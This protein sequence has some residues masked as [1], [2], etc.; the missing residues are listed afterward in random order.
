[1]K[2]IRMFAAS[3]LCMASLLSGCATFDAIK[4]GISGIFDKEGESETSAVQNADAQKTSIG[5]ART[6]AKPAASA[7]KTPES[8]ETAYSY[9]TDKADKTISAYI[10]Q[11]EVDSLRQSDPAA[12]VKK[13]CAKINETAHG[14]FERVK[15]AHDAICILV[16]YDAKNFWAGTVPSQDWQSVVR[17]K[18]AVCEGYANLFQKFAG[19]LGITAQKVSGYARGVGSDITNENP[20]AANHAWNIV[21]IGDAW[22]T[23]DC[24][25]DSGYMSG[26]SSVQS[27]T[28]DW[29]FLKPE[30]F[31]Y[32][33]L[34][35]EAKNQLI[36]PPL[37]QSD[38]LILPDFRPKLFEL[39]NESVSFIKKSMSATDSLELRYQLKDGVSLSFEVR[40]VASGA[41]VSDRVLTEKDGGEVVT[42]FNLPKAGRYSV[43]VFYYLGNSKSGR[44]CGQFLID[45]SSGNN[46][47]YPKL[48]P[49]SAQNVS[50]IEPKQS[51]LEAGKTAHFAV[52]V[53][54]TPV[55]TVIVGKNFVFL[56][57]DG[58]DMFSGDVEIPRGTKQVSVSCGKSKT[59]SFETIAVYSA[60]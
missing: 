5:P 10:K 21:R 9:R 20:R 48:Y 7:Y 47:Q 59:G 18:T 31:V 24:T 42:H 45:A 6:A 44:S 15:L 28:T 58:T 34:P 49:S 8:Y 50:I 52:H 36:Q 4:S 54:G 11:K 46:V 43:M 33:H 39:T 25:W 27:Y 41:V 14:D 23:L 30:Y 3:A 55:V 53:E 37:S 60:K 13:V 12:W 26:K 56:E 19:E 40:D 1:M 32:S 57:N 38:F 16:H 2:G 29:L 17:T 35:T 22:Y 51:P